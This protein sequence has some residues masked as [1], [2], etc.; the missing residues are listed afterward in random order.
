MRI[1]T[2]AHVVALLCVAILAACGSAS[3]GLTSSTPL[4]GASQI[5]PRSARA[6]S[7]PQR[8]EASSVPRPPAGAGYKVLHSFGS[9]TD[10]QYPA[11]NLTV[12]KGSLYGATSGGGA[13]GYGTLFRISTAGVERVLHSFS[14]ADGATP[15]ASLIVLNG[16]LYG[17]TS[18]GGSGS[19]SECGSLGC[20]TIFSASSSGRAR[21][22][23]SFKRFRNG[24]HPS[25]ALA[26]LNGTLYGTTYYGGGG[27]GG[28]GCGTAFTVTTAGVHH[29]IHYFGH[30]FGHKHAPYNPSGGLALLNDTFYG[31][32]LSGGASDAGAVF[33]LRP[34]GKQHVLYSFTGGGG[35]SLP[36]AGVTAVNGSLYGTAFEGGSGTGCP[37]TGGC[38]IVFGVST[39]GEEHLVYSFNY[40]DGDGSFPEASLT[41]A[42]NGTL[43]G[44]TS[45]GGVGCGGSGGCGTVFSVTTDGQETVLHSFTGGSDG[46]NPVAGLTL[47]H[48]TLYGTTSAG[49]KHNEGT[50]FALT[51]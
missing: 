2:S 5:V 3:N 13:L 18:D 34:G 4:S 31:T 50:V 46:A 42:S 17:T 19:P 7:V 25:A 37:G 32:T 28:I 41:A 9:G 16:T 8:W 22:L 10:G 29:V 45:S 12:F 23:Y 24:A 21:V 47:F 30:G 33:V 6:D 11:A 48:G 20:G 27:C 39:D 51:P 49:G 43:Y 36:M 44:T 35:G 14:Y 40:S 1:P 38:G 26:A 15:V